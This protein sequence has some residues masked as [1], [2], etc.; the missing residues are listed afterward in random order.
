LLSDWI[1]QIKRRVAWLSL[2]DGD[3]DPAR[4]WTDFIAALQTVQANL[5]ESAQALLRETGQQ[6]PPRETF[7]TMLLN[8]IAAFPEGFALVLDDYHVITTPTILRP[9]FLLEHLPLQMRVIISSRTDPPLPLARLRAS[10]R[11]TEVRAYDLRFTPDEAA[12]FLNQVMGLDLSTDDIAALE[13][14]TEGWI[15]GLQL[16]ALSLQGR[17]AM[18]KR[19]FCRGVHRRPAHPGL[20]GQSCNA[21]PKPRRPS[22]SRLRPA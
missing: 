15:V 13:V 16:A 11:M 4:F 17:D 10:N 8:E 22:Y 9:S 20:S 14:R 21:S 18:S 2:D 7:L 19:L 1:P 12:L 5:G 6:P 3:N